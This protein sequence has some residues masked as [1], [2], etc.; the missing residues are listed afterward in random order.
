MSDP[1]SNAKI[2]M[3]AWF[4][5]TWVMLFPIGLNLISK[6]VDWLSK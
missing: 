2:V 1:I 4:I 6:F 5:F 3:V